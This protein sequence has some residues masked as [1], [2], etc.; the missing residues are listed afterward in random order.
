MYLLELNIVKS[1]HLGNSGNV[2]TI[3]VYI[4]KEFNVFIFGCAGSLLLVG[5]FSSFSE[6]G[7]LCSC[8]ATSLWC[9]SCGTQA[10]GHVGVSS[11]GPWALERR[12]CSCAWAYLPHDT[13]NLPRSG[14]EPVSPALVGEFF[15]TGLPGKPCSFLL[16]LEYRQH[17]F[18]V[19]VV[20]SLSS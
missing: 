14:I 11:C 20:F 1:L 15:T 6:W 10:R 2:C 17:F 13:W 8:G 4:K 9:F 19:S 7:L 3:R 12:F 18:F 5:L 16:I